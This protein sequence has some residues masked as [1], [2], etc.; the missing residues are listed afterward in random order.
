MQLQAIVDVEPKVAEAWA[1]FEE[2]CVAP[3]AGIRWLLGE[4]SA[5]RTSQFVLMM[6]DR[7][8]RMIL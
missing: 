5:L 1:F 6:Y 2:T 4:S 8:H 7:I 3:T